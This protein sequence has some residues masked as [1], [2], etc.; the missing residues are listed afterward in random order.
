MRSRSCPSGSGESERTGGVEVGPRDRARHACFGLRRPISRCLPASTPFYSDS[1]SYSSHNPILPSSTDLLRSYI[2]LPTY[3]PSQL[4][5]LSNPCYNPTS[6]FLPCFFL[7]VLVCVNTLKQVHFL[8]H[9]LLASL[10]KGRLSIHVEKFILSI[11][12]TTFLT[13]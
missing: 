10:T 6:C 13:K 7:G 2:T 9:Q 1:C 3:L 12:I 11:K 4:D 8:N 5:L